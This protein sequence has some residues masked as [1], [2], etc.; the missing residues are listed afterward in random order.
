MVSEDPALNDWLTTINKYIQMFSNGVNIEQFVAELEKTLT[1]IFPVSR[2][3]NSQNST[4][5]LTILLH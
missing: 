2:A 4:I 1:K 3:I 5:I